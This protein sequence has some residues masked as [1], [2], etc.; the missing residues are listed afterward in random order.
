MLQIYEKTSEMQR[1]IDFSLH[2]RVHSKFRQ[3]QI[4]ENTPNLPNKQRLIM[5][6]F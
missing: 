3:S 1:K 6:I 2:F 5:P 4:Y